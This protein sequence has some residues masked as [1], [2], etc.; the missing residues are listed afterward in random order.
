M[1]RSL[2]SY[3]QTVNPIYIGASV[4]FYTVDGAG[5][6]TS[7]LAT[8]YAA[9]TGSTTL[10]NPQTL[11]SEGKLKQAVYVDD[12]VIATVSTLSAGDHDTGIQRPDQSI[13]AWAASTIFRNGDLV[14]DADS[15]SATYLN[16]YQVAATYTSDSTIA[17]DISNS[18]LTLVYPGHAVTSWA[19]EAEDT[20]IPTAYG[21]DGSTDYSALHHAAKAAAS[22]SSASGSASTATTQASN[23]SSSASTASSAAATAVAAAAGIRRKDNVKAASTANLTLSG[24]QT[25]DGI[26]CVTGDRVL[27]KDQ[28]TASEN[29]IYV[30]DSGA[31][32]RA[33]DL[34]SWDEV[35]NAT[36]AVEQGSVNADRNY[37]VT[38]DS[39]GTIDS[40]NMTWVQVGGGDLVSSNNLSDVS[41]A[42]TARSNLGIDGSSGN[43]AS[44]DLA[45]DAVTP[46]KAEPAINRQTGST[47][48]FALSDNLK[49]VMGNSGSAQTFTIPTNASVAFGVDT[50]RIDVFMQ[51][52]GVITIQGDTGVT[53][54]G[55]SAGSGDLA[56]YGACSL[57]KV[58]TNTWL[59]VGL[60]VS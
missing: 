27:A 25:I 51:G 8:L 26:S 57:Y 31:W 55:V 7:T 17:A 22:A 46:A 37:Q 35:P 10:S 9:E 4:S 21:G 40:T 28:S 13:Q 47:Y 43:I 52:A 32:T 36:V 33:T 56:Q 38:S 39:G 14:Y 24:E 29:G 16:I 50:T 49:T 58:A 20:L 19:T 1:P 12:A 60:T 48:T 59:A 54:N 30:V 44:G 42:A 45:D 18:D 3:F 11:D 23:A 6:K 34:D 53:L 5:A 2:F 41:N 15:A